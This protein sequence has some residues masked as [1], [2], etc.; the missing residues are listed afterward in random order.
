MIT[1]S[2]HY[3]TATCYSLKIYI[4]MINIIKYLQD[5]R[6][7]DL[8]KYYQDYGQQKHTSTQEIVI[9]TFSFGITKDGFTVF[10]NLGQNLRSFK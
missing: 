5:H 10:Q 1:Y 8:I 9:V 4:H 3:R 7:F 6:Q 2:N